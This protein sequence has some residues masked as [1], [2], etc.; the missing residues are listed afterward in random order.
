MVVRH[1]DDGHVF[2]PVLADR[3]IRSAGGV[4]HDLIAR[5]AFGGVEQNETKVLEFSQDRLQVLEVAVVW[6]HRPPQRQRKEAGG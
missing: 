1:L 3:G 2:V 6:P 5:L 4:Q